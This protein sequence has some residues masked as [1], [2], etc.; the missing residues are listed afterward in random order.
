[1]ILG[2]VFLQ[3]LENLLSTRAD[4]REIWAENEGFVTD[5]RENATRLK[6][7]GVIGK[8]DEIYSLVENLQE[9]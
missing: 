3:K 6:V 4:W 7:S 1:M 8:C 9:N 2:P 5:T